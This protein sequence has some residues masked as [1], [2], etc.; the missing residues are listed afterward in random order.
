MRPGR[1]LIVLP[2]N[3]AEDSRHVGVKESGHQ[4]VLSILPGLSG[5]KGIQEYCRTEQ[6]EAPE[7]E[8]GTLCGD[9][10]GS[11]FIYKNDL[12]KLSRSLKNFWRR[13]GDSNSRYLSG[14]H[15]FQ[16]CSFG[17]LGHL[18]ACSDVSSVNRD[19]WQVFFAV[20]W[21][22]LFCHAFSSILWRDMRFFHFLRKLGGDRYGRSGGALGR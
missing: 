2:W 20:L 9:E 18:S 19:D 12:L 21:R 6:F 16:S 11:G 10:T 13:G 17:H 7:S 4:I 5:S 8:A 1:S 22:F 15:D 3:L 14:I